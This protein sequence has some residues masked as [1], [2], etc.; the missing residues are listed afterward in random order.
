MRSK[1]GCRPW[2]RKHSKPAVLRLAVTVFE[3]RTWR[4]A[5]GDLGSLRRLVAKS[6]VMAIGD[7][8]MAITL[9]ATV[10]QVSNALTVD[11]ADEAVI[12][13]VDQGTYVA[14]NATGRKI[15]ALV[16]T[17]LRVDEVCGAMQNTHGGPRERISAD[18]LAFLDQMSEA[19]LVV[20][21]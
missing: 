14:L 16:A 7:G 15:W 9:E 13:S 5:T 17:P 11:V 21:R 4:P 3:C 6:I 2:H 19:N 20:V 10:C 12:L 8:H 1:F 18:V